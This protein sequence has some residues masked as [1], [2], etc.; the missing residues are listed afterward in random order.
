[1]YL[2]VCALQSHA[3]CLIILNSFHKTWVCTCTLRSVLALQRWTHLLIFAITSGVWPALSHLPNPRKVRLTLSQSCYLE[4]I[5]IHFQCMCRFYNSCLLLT[6][7]TFTIPCLSISFEELYIRPSCILAILK[8]FCM[9]TQFSSWIFNKLITYLTWG[10]S[11][12]DF[13]CVRLSDLHSKWDLVLRYVS[14]AHT[15]VCL[16]VSCLISMNMSAISQFVLPI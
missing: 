4:N 2:F 1:M 13:V 5:L 3:K 7:A 14:M 15:Y 11:I 9:A 8:P 16:S 6:S 10:K 12:C